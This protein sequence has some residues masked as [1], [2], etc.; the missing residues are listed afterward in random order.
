MQVHGGNQ[1]LQQMAQLPS[2]HHK[3]ASIRAKADLAQE[4]SECSPGKMRVLTEQKRQ[5]LHLGLEEQW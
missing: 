3:K 1:N 5:G 2:V 4:T